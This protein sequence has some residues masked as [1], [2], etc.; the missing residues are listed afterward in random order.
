MC[1]KNTIRYN[2]RDIVNYCDASVQ[3]KYLFVKAALD[4]CYHYVCIYARTATTE[5]DGKQNIHEINFL[6][7]LCISN[8]TLLFSALTALCPVRW[9][10]ANYH[11]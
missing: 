3:Q 10:V 11:N 9:N 1:I 6:N 8:Y 5:A 7:V 2:L 4:P